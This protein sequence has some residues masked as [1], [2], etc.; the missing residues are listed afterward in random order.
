MNID[1]TKEELEST[2]DALVDINKF[3]ERSKDQVAN[4]ALFTKEDFVQT[5]DQITTLFDLLMTAGTMHIETQLMIE[6]IEN[7]P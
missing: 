5:L 3:I 2:S 4:E 1:F 6:E 7:S